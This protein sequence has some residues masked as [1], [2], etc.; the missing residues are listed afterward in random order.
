MSSQSPMATP[1]MPDNHEEVCQVPARP[2][3][4]SHAGHSQ[5]GCEV[6]GLLN[7]YFEGFI[8]IKQGERCGVGDSVSEGDT[9][10]DEKKKQNAVHKANSM[11]KWV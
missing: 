10:E 6:H 2:E 1:R 8:V 4:Q 3:A 11:W 7:E 9:G 5:D